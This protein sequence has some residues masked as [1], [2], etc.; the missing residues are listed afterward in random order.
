MLFSF[1]YLYVF[2]TYLHRDHGLLEEIGKEKPKEKEIKST[3]ISLLYL[4]FENLPINLASKY[5]LKEE[6]VPNSEIKENIFSEEL[7]KVFI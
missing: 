4:H 3:Q 6:Y 1:S 7:S 2:L 5:S